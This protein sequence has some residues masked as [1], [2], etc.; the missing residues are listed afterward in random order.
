[1]PFYFWAEYGKSPADFFSH[2]EKN[3]EIFGD[4]AMKLWMRTLALLRQFENIGGMFRPELSYM[5]K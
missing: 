1:M 3:M 4:E 2:S 5:P